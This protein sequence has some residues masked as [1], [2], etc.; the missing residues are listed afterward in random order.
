M[1]R[2]MAWGVRAKLPP[3]MF[4]QEQIR[5]GWASVPKDKKSFSDRSVWEGGEPV[6]PSQGH[7]VSG[8]MTD[9]DCPPLP[10]SGP[11]PTESPHFSRAEL[12]LGP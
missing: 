12:E 6:S 4:D 11:H 10:H 1:A 8:V 3:P 9:S 7:T 2:G 5:E